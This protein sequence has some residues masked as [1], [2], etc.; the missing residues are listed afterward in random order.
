M[1]RIRAKMKRKT[2]RDKCNETFP[3]PLRIANLDGI[4]L[5]LPH[6]SASRRSDEYGIAEMF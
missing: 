5:K 3:S 6:S 2:D 4:K 1:P